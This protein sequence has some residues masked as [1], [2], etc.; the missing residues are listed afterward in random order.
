MRMK[1]IEAGGSPS[2]LT[3]SPISLTASGSSHSKPSR[4]KGWWRSHTPT[5]SL[6]T[7]HQAWLSQTESRALSS[8]SS[9]LCLSEVPPC[10]AVPHSGS[11]ALWP[12][13]KY[14]GLGCYRH[15][16]W[17]PEQLHSFSSI[18]KLWVLTPG[19][20]AALS[21][22]QKAHCFPSKTFSVLHTLA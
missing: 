21:S 5:S 11:C 10:P 17:G 14:Y 19:Q 12:L 20:E 4:N 15:C 9:H 16:H 3:K 18:H 22:P 13:S 8:G 2:Q 7:P 6:L 1:G